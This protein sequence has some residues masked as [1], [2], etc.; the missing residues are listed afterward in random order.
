MKVILTGLKG[1]V[2]SEVLKQCLTHPAITSIVALTRRALPEPAA[3]NPKV[4]TVILQDFTSYPSSIPE[5][6]SGAEAY[7]WALG[8]IPS[9]SENFEKDKLIN[10]DFTLTGA[11]AFAIFLGPRVSDKDKKFNFLYIGGKFTER[12]QNANLWIISKYRKMR[13]WIS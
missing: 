6:L 2:G 3:S 10:L 11:N 4:K 1:F 9:K 7:I 5:Q 8:A 13:V 12:D